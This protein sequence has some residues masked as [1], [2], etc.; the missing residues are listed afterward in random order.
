MTRRPAAFPYCRDHDMV[1]PLEKFGQSIVRGL[2]EEAYWFHWQSSFDGEAT[3]RVARLGGE[4][5]FSRL[6]RGSHFGRARMCRGVLSMTDWA[7]IED[8]V[9]AAEFWFLNKCGGERGLDGATWYIAG[10]R[11]REYHF[12]T[13]WSPR[14]ALWDLGRLL[15]DLAGLEEVR[16]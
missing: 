1:A 6:H 8:A 7:L 16:I 15:F 3:I 5:E 10:R 14:N 4:A 13:R 12:I 9:V 2:A 11:R